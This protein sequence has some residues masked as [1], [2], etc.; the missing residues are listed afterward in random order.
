MVR[1][2]LLSLSVPERGKSCGSKKGND[3]PKRVVLFKETKKE[4]LTKI[5]KKLPNSKLAS[6]LGMPLSA[7]VFCSA[8]ILAT[9]SGLA[10][11]ADNAFGRFVVFRQYSLL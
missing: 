9:V 11:D 6:C 3:Y 10:P 1:A 4:T 8:I 5:K 2:T 7:S